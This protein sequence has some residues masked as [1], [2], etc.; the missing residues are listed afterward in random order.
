MMKKMFMVMGRAVG[1]GRGLKLVIAAFF[2]DFL[3]G[4]FHRL[5]S[6]A[7]LE[8]GD[9]DVFCLLAWLSALLSSQGGR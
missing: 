1:V 7:G 4:L 5:T 3:A 2:A 9:T 6:R 8:Q